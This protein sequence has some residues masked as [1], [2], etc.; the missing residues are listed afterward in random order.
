M[1]FPKGFA[2]ELTPEQEKKHKDK[3]KKEDKH[4][5]ELI[6]GRHDIAEKLT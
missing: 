6:S 3:L 5:R 4:I 2:V 1:L